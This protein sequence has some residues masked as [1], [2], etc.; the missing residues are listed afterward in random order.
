MSKNILI[1]HEPI[2]NRTSAITAT[3]LIV[4]ASTSAEAAEKLNLLNDVWPGERTVFVS[5][6]GA[7]LDA[8]LLSWQ[9]QA[10]AMVEI[11]ANALSLPATLALMTQLQ[12]AGVPLCLEGYQPGVVLPAGIDFRFTLASATTPIESAP[13]IALAT[14]LEDSDQLDSCAQKGFGGAT[15]WFF[16]K[17]VKPAKKLNT[18][19]AQIVRLL[20]LVRKNADVKE[21]EAVLKQDVTLSLKMLRYI[22]SAGFGLSV[23]IQSFRHAVTMLGYDKLNRWLS[24]LLVTSSKDAAAPALMQASVTRGRFMELIGKS[25]VDKNET[26]NLFITGAF[27]LIDTLLGVSMDVALAEMTLPESVNEALIDRQ[28]SYAPFLELALA[29]E[30]PDATTYC[31]Q[32][33]GLQLSADTV[34]RALFEALQF[35]DSLQLN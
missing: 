17:G 35:A 24:L 10:N 16:L 9:P 8:G 1:S 32:T 26:D 5:L 22:N 29:C 27:S 11:P 6:G 20:N 28:G 7:P 21:I 3:R 12:Q 31:A 23:E 30:Q 2:L 33:E 15:G 19:Q 34:N 13:G 18:S 14:G 25:F 4:H